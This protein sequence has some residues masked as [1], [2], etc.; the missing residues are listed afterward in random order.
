LGK[1]YLVLKYLCLIHVVHYL[2]ENV[3]NNFVQ[4]KIIDR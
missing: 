3:I 1:N 4:N 2:N